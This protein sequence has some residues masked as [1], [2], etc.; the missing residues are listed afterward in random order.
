MENQKDL[1]STLTKVAETA[2]K[3]AE[4]VKKEG[5]KKMTT[6]YIE[7]QGIELKKID[8]DTYCRMIDALKLIHHEYFET[9][10]KEFQ[11]ILDRMEMRVVKNDL[12]HAPKG[13]IEG[14]PPRY[15]V[16]R[17]KNGEWMFYVDSKDEKP[18]YS[19]RPCMA[20]RYVNYRDAS[21]CADFL[22][23]EWHVLDMEYSMT[24]EERW[25][26]ELRMPMPF[27]A[28]DGNENAIPIEVLT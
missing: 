27:D 13:K 15:A 22:D 9:E 4:H 21:A 6:K 12:F 11:N 23:G 10:N 26:R 25:V 3:L 5:K 2:T 7:T 17:E 28:D 19:D 1:V 14:V 20:K 16:G 24:E 18:M 8:G